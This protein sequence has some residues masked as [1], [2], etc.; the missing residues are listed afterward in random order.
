MGFRIVNATLIRPNECNQVMGELRLFLNRITVVAWWSH[1]RVF[2]P[3]EDRVLNTTPVP[4]S[5]GPFTFGHSG[6]SALSRLK[7]LASLNLICIGMIW[8]RNVQRRADS[9]GLFTSSAIVL[10]LD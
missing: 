7:V 2:V 5:K 4:E 6:A 9:L 8:Y 3:G 1:E 10:K